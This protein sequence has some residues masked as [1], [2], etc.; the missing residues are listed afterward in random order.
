MPVTYY[1]PQGPILKWV[2]TLATER[3]S[4]LSKETVRYN[5]FAD[6]AGTFYDPRSTAVSMAFLSTGANPVVGDWHA[7]TW[8]VSIIGTYVAGIIVGAGGA[9]VLAAGEYYAWIQIVDAT[10]GET[11]VRNVGKLIVQ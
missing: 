9:V 4:T 5:V 2:V 7:G 3:I 11:I 10:A 6:T 8:D 1:T